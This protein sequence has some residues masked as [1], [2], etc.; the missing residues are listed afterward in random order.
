M[1]ATR[2]R[3]NITPERAIAELESSLT[4]TDSD[5]A[6]ALGISPRSLRRWSSGES[7]PQRESRTNLARL[8][9][10]SGRL[11]ETFGKHADE[12]LEA[13]SR[14]LGGLKPIEALRAGRMDRVED[15]LEALD[16]GAVL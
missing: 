15:A 12:W 1:D 9:A 4:M 14:Y 5:V 3:L 7:H 6:R 10:L 8:V 16:S 11:E 2:P 13:D